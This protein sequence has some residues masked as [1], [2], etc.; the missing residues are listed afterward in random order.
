M[1]PTFVVLAG[2][3]I[4]T[5]GCG[6]VPP[7][8]SAPE[9][10]DPAASPPGSEA[11]L[12]ELGRVAWWESQSI[13]FGIIPEAPPDPN[14]PI[15]PGGYRQL[16]VGTLDG[17]V[18]AI[19]ALHDDWAHSYV[20]GPYG[21]DVLVANDTGRGSDV[22]LIS[23][24]DGSRVELFS[25]EGIVAAAALGDDGSS[26]Y[27]VELDRASLRDDGL[28]RRDVDGGPPQRVLEKPIGEGIEIEGPAMYW[29]TADPLDGRI[30]A[31][32]CFGEVRCTSHIVDP[33]SGASISETAIGWPIG[34]DERTF[35][36]DGLASSP[37]VSAWNTRS[38]E[39]QA[40][41]GAARSVP[42]RVGGGWRFVRDEAGVP[43]GRTVVVDADGREEPIA[44]QDPELSSI[45]T[46]GGRRGVVLPPGWVLRWPVSQILTIDGAP[47]PT[48]HGQLIE[49]ATGRRIDL[50]LPEPTITDGADCA[51]PVPAEMPGGER[52][53]S[54]VL[55][56]IGGRR[57]VRWGSGANA[58][59][60]AVGWDPL[61]SLP[62]SEPATVRG[63]PGNIVLIGDEGVGEVALSWEEDGCPY[64]AWMGA[65]TTL[66]LAR[67]Y[68]ERY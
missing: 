37:D 33:G 53:G 44:G 40:I 46:V 48:G 1:R 10:T 31:Q 67:D 3:I 28:W 13:G 15:Q 59:V 12:D 57:T 8:S 58:V 63:L 49:V 60:L 38:G 17:R 34:A 19:L 68:A 6:E 51:V 62:A 50:P 52:V 56:M 41:R 4:L 9:S 20:A 16:T 32:Y 47:M 14:P 23:A 2:L 61:G 26:I 55:E 54:G 66:E 22:F 7:P 64:T 39:V 27:Y 11:P 43:E 5:A 42:V 29:L 25:A 35:F 21:T 24:L 45:G 65:G 36:G 18:T 30:V